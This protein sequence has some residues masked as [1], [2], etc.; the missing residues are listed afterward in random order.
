MSFSSLT[1]RKGEVTVALRKMKKKKDDIV[2]GRKKRIVASLI[3]F[4]FFA[5]ITMSLLERMSLMP[6]H[7]L[8]HTLIFNLKWQLLLQ[9]TKS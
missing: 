6:L 1:S 9:Y 7:V 5:S 2:I 8:L 3:E 4:V